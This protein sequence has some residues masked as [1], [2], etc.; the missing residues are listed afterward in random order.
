MS[1]KE[2]FSH[3]PRADREAW[4]SEQEPEVLEEIIRGAW[5]W[6]ARPAQV[7]PP[8]SWSY[9]LM[10]AGRGFGKTRAGAE[11]IVE[12]ATLYPISTSGNP[13]EHLVVGETISDARMICLEG[14]SGILNALS[15]RGLERDSDFKYVK[16]P[17]P[18]IIFSSGARIYC[19]GADD[20]DV[21]RG[22]NLTSA[23]LD[24]LIKWPTATAS[25]DEG[26][27]PALRVDI[28]GD[29]PRVFITTT[30]KAGSAL[31]KR[32]L[33]DADS[34]DPQRHESIQIIRG[35]TFDNSSNLNSHM[36]RNLRN[37]YEGT[38]LGQQE[39]YGEVIEVSSG[40]LFRSQDLRQ[41]RVEEIPEDRRVVSIIVG[42]DPSLTDEQGDIV[43]NAILRRKSAG[44]SSDEMGVVVVARTSDD[45]WWVL[46]DE[47]VSLAG[48][49]AALHVWRTMLK[50]NATQVIY[51]ENLG[52]KWMKQVFFDTYNEL[53]K[54]ND[55]PSGTR[56]PMAGVD[57]KLGKKTRA[58]P[59]AGRSQQHRLHMVG[60]FEKLESQMTEFTSWDGKE[61]P[62][63]LD[64]LVHACRQHMKN[65]RNKARIV[66]PRD[67]RRDLRFDDGLGEGFDFRQW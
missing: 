1:L 10:L 30:P 48:R 39:L 25:F 65:E 24:E 64:A 12:R 5:W 31:L 54:S 23:W 55:M 47:T 17:K 44:D 21:G 2:R 52:K 60:T 11:W 40:A 53:V 51:E 67:L 59:I 61:S 29:H 43:D 19:E 38:T 22:Y 8:G 49:D 20:A 33:A 14:D 4:L 41:T 46:A 66:D 18:M 15:R 45:H 7:P 36:L 37:R 57:A 27:V 16:S 42:V 35:S 62:D 26:I 63:R 56:P 34:S 50:W 9:F 58:E 32:F 3:L 28:E 13:T 6:E